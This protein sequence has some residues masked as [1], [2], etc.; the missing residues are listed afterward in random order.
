MG[1]TQCDCIH[2]VKEWENVNT[3]LRIASKARARANLKFVQG[4]S[5]C[6]VDFSSPSIK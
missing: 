2:G 6:P 5:K 3:E 4:F 1:Y